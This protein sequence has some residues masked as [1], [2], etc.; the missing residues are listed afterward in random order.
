MKHT[1]VHY[2]AW[3]SANAHN[4]LCFPARSQAGLKM[5]K[6]VSLAVIPHGQRVFGQAVGLSRLSYVEGEVGKGVQEPDFRRALPENQECMNVRTFS[7]RIRL[8]SE[9]R[10]CLGMGR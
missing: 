6:L 8:P 2:A 1:P 3:R 9:F 5:N 10:L 4:W 7:V